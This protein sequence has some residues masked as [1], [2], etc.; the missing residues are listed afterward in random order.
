MPLTLKNRYVNENKATSRWQAI[1]RAA[2]YAP[3]SARNNSYAGFLDPRR[4]VTTCRWLNLI[5]KMKSV[6][7]A[8][9][10]ASSSL[11]VAFGNVLDYRTTSK[12]IGDS[13]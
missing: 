12:D 8:R 6:P 1:F 7:T 3:T 9:K 5:A 2:L 10:K 13:Q 4:S 11:S